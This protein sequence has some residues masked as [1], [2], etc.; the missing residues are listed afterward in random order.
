MSFR[1]AFW[2][3]LGHIPET[4]WLALTWLGDSGLLLPMALLLTLWFAVP[5]RTRPSACL[6]VL[7]FG[8]AGAGILVSKLAFMGWGL[9][10]ARL[11]F[12]GIS[13]HTAIS[14]SVWPVALWLLS[15]RASHR[16]RVALVVLGWLLA[17]AIGVSRLA[18]YAHSGSEVAAGLALGVATSGCFLALQRRLA[19]PAQHGALVALS[20]MAPLLLLHPGERAPTQ[21]ALEGIAVRLAGVERPFTRADLQQRGS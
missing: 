19:P 7:C 12:T 5:R 11:N 1:D 10:S 3:A 9:G 4:F 2:D 20:L 18:L 14:A 13:G 21:Q 6:W 16:L 17:A 15:S 8:L